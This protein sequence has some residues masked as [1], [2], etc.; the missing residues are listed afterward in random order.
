MKHKSK[1]WFALP[2]LAAFG[3]GMWAAH[4]Q[5]P[6]APPADDVR[7][8]SPAA[9]AAARSKPSDEIPEGLLPEEKATIRLFKKSMRSVVY[10][11]TLV[12][13]RGFFNLNVTKIP[14]GTG[15]GFF[16]DTE[17][18]IV[19]NYHVIRG[20]DAARI[21]LSDGS[22]YD[23]TLVGAAPD[24]DIA[25]LMI[26]APKDKLKALR[27]GSSH[28]L[29]VGQRVHAIGNP[30]GLDQTLT[31]GIISALGREIQSMTR[32]PIQDVIQ[33]DAAINPGNSGGPLLD[34]SGRLIGVNTQIYSPSGAF[35]GIGFAVPVDIVKRI[36]PELILHGK[37]TRP[38]L[39]ILPARDE[40]TR[41]VGV[42]GVLILNVTKNSSADKAQL[43]PTRRDRFGRIHLG[44][45]LTG[46]DDRQIRE[47][48]DLFK[49]LDKYKVGDTVTLTYLR[50]KKKRQTRL[51]LQSLD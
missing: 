7:R 1:A 36:V 25:V 45:I 26:D 30:F 49:A 33:T 9:P 46:I 44:D 51:K 24:K 27:I 10:I 48:N 34:S 8:Q 47:L 14:A 23:A 5:R 21:T 43:R 42:E 6:P 19:T 16:W 17:G 4:P 20:A 28:D 50:D 35:A 31:M 37:V 41:Q 32:R 38:G 39:G 18:H 13:R 11:T 22:T 3:L 2:L 40:V 29:E 15:S 12:V